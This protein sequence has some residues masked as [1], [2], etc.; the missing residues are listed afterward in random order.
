MIKHERLCNICG[1]AVIQ[2]T[3]RSYTNKLY[4]KPFRIEYEGGCKYVCPLCN[5]VA[6]LPGFS[7]SEEASNVTNCI[8]CGVNLVWDEK[9]LD[10]E[11][12]KFITVAQALSAVDKTL[13]LYK[14][15]YDALKKELRNIA[16]K[17]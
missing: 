13:N 16:K 15:D 12:N 8:C 4:L 7:F 1:E 3:E 11:D 9:K 2:L 10:D 17:K 14:G 5:S 6:Q